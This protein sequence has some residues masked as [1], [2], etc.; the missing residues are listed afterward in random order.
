[1]PKQ[2]RLGSTRQRIP[3]GKAILHTEH[4]IT[5]PIEQCETAP[6]GTRNQVRENGFRR[7]GAKSQLAIPDQ[8]GLDKTELIKN[9]H[10]QEGQPQEIHPDNIRKPGSSIRKESISTPAPAQTY[11]ELPEN[12]LQP[13]EDQDTIKQLRMTT[14]TTEG[15]HQPSH[16][17]HRNGI[18]E[19]RQDRVTT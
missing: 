12:P 10:A 17:G 11:T 1:M 9:R 15:M 3:K 18:Q 14:K 13:I 6:S 7:L 2:D 16:R 8:K 5:V 4:L 19:I